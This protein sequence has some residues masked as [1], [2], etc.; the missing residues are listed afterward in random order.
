MKKKK[1]WENI[2][3]KGLYIK[4]KLKELNVKYNLNLLIA[5]TNGIP[6]FSFKSKN[7]L[8][9]KTLVTQ[10][11]LKQKI[12]ASNII[13]LS[14]SHNKN[15]FEEYFYYLDKVFKKISNCEN[16]SYNINKYIDGEICHEGFKRLN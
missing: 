7:N 12:L 3:K 10:E 15:N 13:Y 11:L 16:N 14:T 1:T 2:S 8:K 4:K 9:Y 5:G 6:S